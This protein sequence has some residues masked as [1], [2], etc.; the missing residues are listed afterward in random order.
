LRDIQT[1]LQEIDLTRA[2]PET[3]PGIAKQLQE[4]LRLASEINERNA[5]YIDGTLKHNA[6]DN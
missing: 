2:S 1:R 6:D 4:I 3:H 5:K